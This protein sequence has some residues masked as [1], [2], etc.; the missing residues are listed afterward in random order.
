MFGRS[1]AQATAYI[2]QKVKAFDRDL[3]FDDDELM[4]LMKHHP[5]C[6]H[7]NVHKFVR[8]ARPPFYKVSLF[9]ITK[10]GA[11]YD[12]CTTK[13]L[14]KMY[15]KFDPEQDKRKV[16]IQAFRQE[17]NYTP[18]MLKA[19][20]KYSV[21]PCESCGKNCKLSVD[22][23]DKPFSQI[24]DEF[25]ELNG[26]K[27]MDVKVR[28]HQRAEYLLHNQRL[29]KQWHEFHDSEATFQGLCRQ[30]NSAKGSGG[31]RLKGNSTINESPCSDYVAIGNE[32]GIRDRDQTLGELSQI[33]PVQDVCG[34][35]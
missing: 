1:L 28:W 18:A 32:E 7:N 17:T 19:K 5:S 11:I 14:R 2:A 15:G 16:I 13:C 10:T 31:Y 29:S 23:K 12:S 35:A 34:G 30:C 20:R 8:Q 22:H 25:L 4:E 3:P 33:H 9:I 24:L 21:G 26:L 27:L 6:K